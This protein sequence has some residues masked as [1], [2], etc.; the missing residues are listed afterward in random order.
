MTNIVIER[1]C[2]VIPETRAHNSG[3]QINST[4]LLVSFVKLCCVKYRIRKSNHIYHS[5]GLNNKN[6]TT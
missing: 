5:F 4:D 2:I 3:I 6:K 1:T